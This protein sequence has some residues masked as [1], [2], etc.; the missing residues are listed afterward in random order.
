[1][2]ALLS[3]QVVPEY[4]EPSLPFALIV[5]PSDKVSTEPATNEIRPPPLPPL[6][7]RGQ[8]LFASLY[9]ALQYPPPPEPK[10]H[11]FTAEPCAPPPDGYHEK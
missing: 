10:A 9:S 2:K 3:F 5:A 11:G 1:M 8:P 6:V 7:V 4:V